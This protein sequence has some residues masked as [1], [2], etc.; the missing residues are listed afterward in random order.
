M[1]AKVR[2]FWIDVNYACYGLGSRGGV[3]T[4]TPPIAAWMKGK[5]LENLRW[6]FKE[7]KA[8]VVEI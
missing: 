7:K 3:I 4:D 8:K 1:Q 5:R 2:W 6:W